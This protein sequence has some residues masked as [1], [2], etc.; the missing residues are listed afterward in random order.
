MSPLATVA[1]P[2]LWLIA[3]VLVGL[4]VGA[5][6]AAIL[7]LLWRAAAPQAAPAVT[8]TLNAGKL[9]KSEALKRI[10]EL[11]ALGES[12][13]GSKFSLTDAYGTHV[14]M[15]VHYLNLPADASVDGQ[16]CSA[17]EREI[18]WAL[19]DLPGR[20]QGSRSNGERLNKVIAGLRGLRSGLA[21]TEY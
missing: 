4:L 16:V 6:L 7:W 19:S 21:A 11:I 3:A 14:Q 18:V 13:D 20:G 12:I 8:G 1:D 15:F 9:V 17:I 10:D 5:A 2:I